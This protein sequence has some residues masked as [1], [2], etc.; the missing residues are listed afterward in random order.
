MKLTKLIEILEHHAQSEITL[1]LPD[2]SCV[3]PH[4]H[5]TEVGLIKRTFIDCG[6]KNH[7][8]E[9]ALLQVW[10]AHDYNHRVQAGKLAQII[11][12]ATHVIP[13]QELEVEFEHE[14]PV[15]TQ[16]PIER[17][18]LSEGMI[19]LYLRYK[20]TDCL[21]KDICLPKPDFTLPSM[22]PNSESHQSFK[23][24]KDLSL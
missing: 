4:F 13:S 6:G 24:F 2:D 9:N 23:L 19:T 8:K 16:L 10:I 7:H 21:A 20:A 11:R 1:K 5:I 15:L 17:Y 18:E 22:T 14:A 12:K 3:P